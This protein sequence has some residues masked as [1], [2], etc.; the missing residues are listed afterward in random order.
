MSDDDLRHAVLRANL[1]CVNHGLVVSTFGNASGIDRA[2]GRI[3]IK[4]SGVP[5][6]RLSAGDMVACDLDGRALDN[7][8]RPS[9]DLQTHAVLYRAFPG[10][11]GVVHT[12]S[13]YATIMAQ[14]RRPIPCLGTTHADYFHGTIPVTRDL[15]PDEIA[16]DYV[17]MTGEVIAET[18]AAL[19]PLA[20]PAVL[21]AGH[22]PF[23]WGRTPDE[24]AHNALILEEVARMAWHC[25]VLDPAPQP[26]TQALLDRH[27]LRKHGAGATY[28]Q[29]QP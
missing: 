16:R 17:L 15:T 10:I 25:M 1:D 6:D 21:V 22:G 29:G 9:S 7:R 19:D 4:P 3:L 20:I 28:G 26:I 2:A 8:L 18:F 11:G 24:A 12:H 14:A 27:Y 23:V 5:Y 13:T